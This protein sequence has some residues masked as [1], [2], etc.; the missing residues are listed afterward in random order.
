MIT[1]SDK[2]LILK[3]FKMVD[4][5]KLELEHNDIRLVK[6]FRF[7]SYNGLMIASEIIKGLPEKSS[8][9]KKIKVT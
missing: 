1:K 7:G 9:V 5:K 3:A 6:W 4:V 2:D 8:V